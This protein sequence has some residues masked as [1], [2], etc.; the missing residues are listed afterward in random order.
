M[1]TNHKQLTSKITTPLAPDFPKAY[2]K[3][4]LPINPKEVKIL[5]N[6]NNGI[7]GYFNYRSNYIVG[8]STNYNL[9]GNGIYD[10]KA[11]LL[12]LKQF[13]AQ[14]ELLYSYFYQVKPKFNQE[15]LTLKADSITKVNRK[16][17]TKSLYQGYLAEQNMLAAVTNG[18]LHTYNENFRYFM[19]AGIFGTLAKNELRSKKNLVVAATTL[20]TRAAIAG[21][22]STVEAYSMSD[23]IIK[24]SEE[25]REIT[26][27][28]EYT[29]AIGELFLQRVQRTKRQNMPPLIYK[30]Q[31][32]IYT[33]LTT[34][35]SV[36]EIAAFLGV[37]QSYLMHLFKE[38]TGTSLMTYVNQLK[39]NEACRLLVF[40]NKSLAE[41]AYELGFSSQ[42]QFSRNFKAYVKQTPL[43][44]RKKMQLQ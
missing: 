9:Q 28:Y 14:M 36:S 27:I 26:N 18:D 25:K 11:P 22:L 34:I 41:I 12:G 15:Q 8:W 37:S 23:N 1:F 31:E 24:D 32:Y 38:V 10:S 16:A 2:K 19:H 33:N 5:T 44:Y 7:L 30:A 42:S 39:I 6:Q 35:E 20:Y 43:S 29:R 13:L 21:G 17:T 40:S 4:L 3:Q